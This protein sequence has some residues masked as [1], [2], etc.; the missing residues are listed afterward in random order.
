MAVSAWARRAQRPRAVARLVDLATLWRLPRSRASRHGRLGRSRRA[1]DRG[2]QPSWT[3]PPLPAL[4]PARRLIK[5]VLR[6]AGGDRT[7][8]SPLC[9]VGTGRCL[10]VRRRRD[11]ACD[12]EAPISGHHAQLDEPARPPSRARVRLSEPACVRPIPG[13]QGRLRWNWANPTCWPWRMSAARPCRTCPDRINGARSLPSAETYRPCTR[14]GSC[15]ATS[16]SGMRSARG[17]AVM[18]VDF[19]HAAD[20]GDG[21]PLPGGS[22]GHIAPEQGR[23]AHPAVDVFALGM[24]LAHVTSGV[25]PELCDD[26]PSV[27]VERIIASGLARHAALVGHA[28]HPCPNQRPSA[29]G[30]CAMR[31]PIYS[32][33]SFNGGSPRAM[34]SCP[35]TRPRAEPFTS[36]PALRTTN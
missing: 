11:R 7:R 6:V 20:I 16:S 23:P 18:L 35:S 13:A 24:C 8:S 25:D 1:V 34:S 26:A 12:R 4:A 32:R 29:A 21:A 19:E 5:N 2:S 28:T 31:S 17:D 10:S 30:R 27:F 36:R 14:S 9:G 3:V 15:T 22:R 33:P